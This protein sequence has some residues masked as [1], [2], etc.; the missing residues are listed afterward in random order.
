MQP[1]HP[2]MLVQLLVTAWITGVSNSESVPG[3]R[4]KS[5]L[6]QQLTANQY[7]INPKRKKKNLYQFLKCFIEVPVLQWP[8]HACIQCSTGGSF[9]RYEMNDFIFKFTDFSGKNCTNQKLTQPLCSEL[10][11]LFFFALCRLEHNKADASFPWQ[12]NTPEAQLA[13]TDDSDANRPDHLLPIW[14]S[15]TSLDCCF[16]CLQKVH[17]VRP[18]P[19]SN[20]QLFCQFSK[21]RWQN[22]K[23]DCF[24]PFLLWPEYKQ[25]AEPLK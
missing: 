5:R 12:P 16:W 25:T 17:L 19:P 15:V 23:S 13:F 24:C 11:H 4:S 1:P 8:V 22:K 20:I 18:L 3:L 21:V 2:V 7:S 14:T 9:L 6:E 10:L